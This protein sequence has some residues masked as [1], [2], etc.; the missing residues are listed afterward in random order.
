MTA[1]PDLSGLRVLVPRPRPAGERTAEYLSRLGAEVEYHPA[2]DIRCIPA[3]AANNDGGLQRGDLDLV[4][5]V[6]ANAVHCLSDAPGDIAKLCGPGTLVA[7]MGS[8]TAAACAAAGIEVKF[9][10]RKSV[11][12]EGLIR[13][14]SGA[15]WQGKNVV[16]VRGRGGRE[17]LRDYLESQGAQVDYLE[18]YERVTA[19]APATAKIDRWCV[20]GFDAVVVSSAAV[21]D[22]M[23]EVFSDRAEELFI[24]CFLVCPSVRVGNV[25][26]HHGFD[27]ILVAAGPGDGDTARALAQIDRPNS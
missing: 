3:S 5:F 20:A 13:A 19:A 24:S 2:L 11:D 26:R 18:A 15:D 23:L 8:A 17:E 10:P 9:T 1:E 22:A 14:L 4:V 21:F 7:T 16:I 6:S 12:S 27:R 25:C